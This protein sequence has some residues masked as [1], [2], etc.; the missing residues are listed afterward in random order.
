LTGQ[1]GDDHLEDIIG[2]MKEKDIELNVMYVLSTPPSPSPPYPLP[3]L[4]D[5]IGGM[6]EK[7]IELNV[8]YVL[9]TPPI[10]PRPLPFIEDIIV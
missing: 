4:E 7:D 1:F 2:G 9:S 5:I 3:C 8:M 10:P 6:K